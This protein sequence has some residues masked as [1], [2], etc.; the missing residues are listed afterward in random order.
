[1]IGA[2]KRLGVDFMTAHW[3]FTYGDERVLRSLEELKPVELLA[4]NVRTV[5][6]EEPVFKPYALRE[7][8]GVPLAVIG[9][10]FPY[11][12][13]ANPRHQVPEWTFGIQEKRLQGHVDEV[14]AKGAR[15]VVLLSHNGLDVDLKLASRLRGI[16]AILGGHTHDAVPARHP[17]RRNAGDERRLERQVHRRARP[18]GARRAASPTTVTA[19]CRYSRTCSSADAGMAAYIDAVRKP[20]DR[21]GWSKGWRAP[22]ACSIAA[23]ASTA[24]S[25]I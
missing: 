23:A 12:P 4:Q 3:E 21:P 1:M 13:I 8:N 22:K 2:Q 6:F 7:L 10:A 19:C 18:G 9:Q 14:R 24:A 15:V 17:R 5:D 11:T 25:T 20:F 16:D